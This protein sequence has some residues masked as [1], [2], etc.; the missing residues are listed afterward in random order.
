MLFSWKVIDKIHNSAPSTKVLA[1]ALNECSHMSS[2]GG[3]SSALQYTTHFQQYT[4]LSP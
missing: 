1:Q 3:R 2:Q 4:Q